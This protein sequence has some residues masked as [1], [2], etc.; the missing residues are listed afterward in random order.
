MSATGKRTILLVAFVELL[1]VCVRGAD[2]HGDIK[3][4]GHFDKKTL[5]PALYDL[6][7]MEP[8]NKNAASARRDSFERVAVWLEPDSTATVQ[9]KA[10]SANEAVMQ[11]RNRHFEPSLLIIAPGTKVVFPNADAIFHNIFSFSPTLPFD[12][13]Y[14]A[15]GKSREIVFP[16]PGVA[17]VYCHVHPEMYGVIIVTPSQ[18]T[19]RPSV[20]GTFSFSG[21][22]PGKYKAVLWQRAAGLVRKKINI[23]VS[24][25]GLLSFVIPEDQDR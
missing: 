17:Q 11:Q 24:G 22:P 23:P 9:V 16:R 12:L 25:D 2:L 5:S 20:D 15:E 3:I 13:G 4:E 8:R 19:T 10:A 14:Y 21:V 6:R 18:W 1:A 7:G